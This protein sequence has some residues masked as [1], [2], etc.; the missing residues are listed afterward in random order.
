MFIRRWRRL[1]QMGEGLCG[2]AL[3]ELPRGGGFA[4]R[5]LGGEVPVRCLGTTTLW[6]LGL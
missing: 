4:R 5:P 1:T 6:L 3:T 2:W